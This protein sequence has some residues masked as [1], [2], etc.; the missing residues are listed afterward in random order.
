MDTLEKHSKRFLKDG[1]KTVA[2][3]NQAS[4]MGSRNGFEGGLKNMVTGLEQYCKAMPSVGYHAG[5][6]GFIGPELEN[7][8]R[9]LRALLSG[10][11][12]FDGG[13]IDA[14]LLE[15]CEKAKLDIE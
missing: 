11:G 1:I 6:D 15:I 12:R 3:S 9:S 13:T 10:G 2:H 5:E 7:I 8:A 14:A 4:F